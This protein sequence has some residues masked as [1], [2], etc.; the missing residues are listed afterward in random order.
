MFDIL[1]IVLWVSVKHVILC[2]MI[3][4]C[5]DMRVT[6]IHNVV[7]HE[8]EQGNSKRTYYYNK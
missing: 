8:Q 1:C 3:T 5:S 7:Y 4:A 6:R 2:M